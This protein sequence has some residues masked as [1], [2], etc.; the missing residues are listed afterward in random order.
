MKI[1]MKRIIG[2][3]LCLQIILMSGS[4]FRR[5]EEDAIWRVKN[6]TVEMSYNNSSN[7]LVIRI[8]KGSKLEVESPYKGND[9]L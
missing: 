8:T 1:S 5:S 9:I 3:L 7:K 4:K 2:G 6:G